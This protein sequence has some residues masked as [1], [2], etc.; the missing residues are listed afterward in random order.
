MTPAL[1]QDALDLLMELSESGAE[2]VVVGGHALAVHG[3]SRATADLDVLVR[4][5][6]ANAARVVQALVGFGAPL[7]AHGVSALDFEREGTIYQMGLP[8]NRVDVLTSVDGLTFDQAW[9]GRVAVDVEGQVV[10]FLGFAELIINKRAAGRT[11]DLAD[12]EALLR[13]AHRS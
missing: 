10:P 8:P 5:S 3:V 13:V 11:K 2:F 1:P 4:A 6:A 12:V 7:R 9:A